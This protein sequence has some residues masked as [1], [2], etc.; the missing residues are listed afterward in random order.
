MAM[1]NGIV[2]YMHDNGWPVW[3]IAVIM[4][5]LATGR[6]FVNAGSVLF[7]R[8]RREQDAV[9]LST[10]LDMAQRAIA[11]SKKCEEGHAECQGQLMLVRI[12]READRARIDELTAR[13]NNIAG[14][15]A[16]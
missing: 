5:F 6:N 13:L 14:G 12:D 16:A 4:F 15:T 9:N 11:A 1:D 3:V 10:A 7:N 2:Q 8:K